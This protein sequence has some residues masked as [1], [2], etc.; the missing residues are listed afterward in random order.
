MARAAS[1]K[2]VLIGAVPPLMVKT[3]K[4]PGGLPIEVFDGF[5]KR[6]GANRAQ[7]FLDVPTG[8]FYGFNRP[9]A[10][11]SEGVICN[12]WRQ[13]MMGGAKAH[14]DCIK[15]FSETDFTEDLKAIDVPTFV[16]H[17][18]DDQIV[19]IDDSAA[20]RDRAVEEGHAE[21]PTPA[22]RMHGHDACRRD[23]RRPARIHRRPS[24]SSTDHKTVDFKLEAVVLPVADVDI[25]PSVST[26]ASGGGST[27]TS[28]SATD[29]ARDPVS[30]RPDHPARS[31]SARASRPRR[32]APH[33][34]SISS[35]PTSWAAREA[36]VELG[37]RRE[38]GVPPRGPGPAR[39]ERTA[40]AAQQLLV[41]RDVQ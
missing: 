4:N 32:R 28:S 18:E 17:G 33:R 40:S 7:F 19:P 27:P 23:Q 24:M 1:R 35:C 34:G 14:Y 9:H 6:T 2:A 15:A 21:E 29:S 25:A 20:P 13:G 30:R 3:T 16:M 26:G 41:V 10:K 22:C 31:T 36:L 12:W 37:V 38:R 8:P 39:R 11:P 5:R